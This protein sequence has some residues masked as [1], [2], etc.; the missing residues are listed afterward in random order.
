MYHV[1]A[2]CKRPIADDVLCHGNREATHDATVITL[3]ETARA[4]RLTFNAKKF[5]FKSQDCHLGIKW[6]LRNHPTLHHHPL[7]LQ[8]LQSYLDLVNY[9]NRFSPILA[10]LTSPLR[11]LCKKDTLF[12]WD[13]TQQATF[14]AI[15][16][17][18]TRAPVI[19]PDASKKGLGAVILQDG[20]PVVYSSRS[21]T[22]TEQDYSN[23]ARSGDC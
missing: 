18:I 19:Q 11:A 10:E 21:L 9:L 17:E 20:K 15:E 8:D 2:S 13:S 23:I 12:T 7:P 14:E 22:V 6:I 16:K 4:N 5:V 1:T 3:L